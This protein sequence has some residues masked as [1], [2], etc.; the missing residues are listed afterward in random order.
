MK[1]QQFSRDGG[2]LPLLL[3]NIHFKKAKN[4]FGV[5]MDGSRLC[6]K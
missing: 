5:P 6:D 3:Y 1:R 4:A 2:M